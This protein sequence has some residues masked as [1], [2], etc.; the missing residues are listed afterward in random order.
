MVLDTTYAKWGIHATLVISSDISHDIY[1]A[2]LSTKD[3]SK[4]HTALNQR[5]IKVYMDV[6]GRIQRWV[7]GSGPPGKSQ[8]YKI[9]YQYWSGS[10]KNRKATKPAF[11]FGPLSASQRH[12][13]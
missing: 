10:P 8:K 7:R 11:N 12:G 6:H 9:S 1:Y 2:L 5:H 3:T 4:Y 13:I